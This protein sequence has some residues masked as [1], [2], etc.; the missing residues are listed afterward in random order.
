MTPP[1]AMRTPT[2]TSTQ[3]TTTINHAGNGVGKAQTSKK[4]LGAC[5]P[6]R[7]HSCGG[8][9]RGQQ[10]GRA[11]RERGGER[12]GCFLATTLASAFLLVIGF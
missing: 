8:D 5:S 10:Q 11:G 6:E 2:I 7:S 12:L 4:G 9:R 3:P 1:H